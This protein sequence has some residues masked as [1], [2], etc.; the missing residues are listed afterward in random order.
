KLMTNGILQARLD[1]DRSKL[2]CR[3]MADR[4]A[5]LAG[6]QLGWDQLAEGLALRDAVA[7]ADAVSAIEAAENNRGN[8]GVPWV[9]GQNAGGAGQAAIRVVG[10]ITRAGYNLL[11]GRG[12]TDPS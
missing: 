1:Y 7:S 11:N 10:D 8:N 4:M 9:G 3:Q 2:T 12:I 6:G 5:E